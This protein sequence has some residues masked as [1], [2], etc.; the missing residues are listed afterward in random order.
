MLL[1]AIRPDGCV[2]TLLGETLQLSLEKQAR[3]SAL[4][5]A[6]YWVHR[7]VHYMAR[8]T[9]TTSSTTIIPSRHP[10]SSGGACAKGTLR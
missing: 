3:H 4:H 5:G 6:L 7:I 9:Y 8:G 10:A 1:S 2:W